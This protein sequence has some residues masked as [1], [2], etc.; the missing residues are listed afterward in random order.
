M[1][2]DKYYLLKY[3]PLIFGEP[4]NRAYKSGLVPENIDI[5]IEILERALADKISEYYREGVKLK[6]HKENEQR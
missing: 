2:K 4:L 6:L 1:S 3:L 5:P